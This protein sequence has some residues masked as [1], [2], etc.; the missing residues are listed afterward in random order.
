MSV[1]PRCDGIRIREIDGSWVAYDRR[2]DR[3]FVLDDAGA[4]IL[5]HC[6]G[7]RT[8]PE[9]AVEVARCFA[10]DAESAAADAARLVD[11]FAT[12]GLVTLPCGDDR[13]GTERHP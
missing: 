13:P 3:I 6:D 8:V 5:Q 11:E 7:S 12:M 10:I 1:A 4:F 2:T 9:I